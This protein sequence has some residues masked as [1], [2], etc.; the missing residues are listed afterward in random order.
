MKYFTAD[1]LT[2]L[3]SPVEA[4]ANAADAEWDRRLEQYEEEVRRMEPGLPDH[5]RAYHALL[6]HDARVCCMA[7][8]E[9]QLILVLHKDIPPRDLVVITY[10]LAGEPV[11]DRDVLPATARSSVMNYDY[12]EFS[13]VREGD[14]SSYSESI[15]FSNGWEVQLRFH[16][17]R[18]TLAD[19]LYAIPPQLAAG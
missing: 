11:I 12:N 5:I 6:L 7:R 8:H 14:T 13:L 4:E 19:P 3:N 9:D 18:F 15:L 10:M 17:V 1:L 16:D 2:R